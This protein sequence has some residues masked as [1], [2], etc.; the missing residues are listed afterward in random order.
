MRGQHGWAS[1]AATAALVAL[2]GCTGGGSQSEL[3]SPEPSPSSISQSSIDQRP[4]PRP[5]LEPH[6]YPPVGRYQRIDNPTPGMLDTTLRCKRID[7]ARYVAIEGSHG[8]PLRALALQ[9]GRSKVVVGVFS[10]AATIV[11]QGPNGHPTSVTHVERYTIDGRWWPIKGAQCHRSVGAST[12]ESVGSPVT[13]EDLDGK[14]H[15]ASVLGQPVADAKGYRGQITFYDGD[16]SRVRWDGSDGCNTVT[17]LVRLGPG[18]VFR[19]TAVGSTLIRC[20]NLPD[21]PPPVTAV[22]G[23]ARRA[24]LTGARLTL[25]GDS[26][27]RIATFLRS[28]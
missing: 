23:K 16:G 22:L 6:V 19:S 3:A 14:W 18:R 27:T 26:G 15:A 2:S 25:Y 11:Q 24:G 21:N 9:D 4:P 7:R 20:T 8:Y 10:N 17:G 13:A 5:Q 12:S 28:L 1:A